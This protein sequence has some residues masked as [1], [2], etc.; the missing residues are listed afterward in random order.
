MSEALDGARGRGPR[1]HELPAR[2]G[3]R[4]LLRREHTVGTAPC[5]EVYFGLIGITRERKYSH[6]DEVDGRAMPRVHEGGFSTVWGAR[7]AIDAVDMAAWPVY[8]AELDQ[9]FRVWRSE[10]LCGGRGH[11]RRRQ[12]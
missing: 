12:Q 1:L 4:E 11:C 2:N 8:R 5:Q 10:P 9:Y 3:R 7:A 6:Q